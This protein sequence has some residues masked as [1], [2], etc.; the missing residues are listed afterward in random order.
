MGVV[1]KGF[2]SLLAGAALGAVSLPGFL[3]ADPAFSGEAPGKPIPAQSAVQAPEIR[4]YQAPEPAQSALPDFQISYT[5]EQPDFQPTITEPPTKKELEEIDKAK[6]WLINGYDAAIKA[7]DAKKATEQ[8][9]IQKEREKNHSSGDVRSLMETNSA[10]VDNPVDFLHAKDQSSDPNKNGG[11]PLQNSAR[12]DLGFTPYKPLISGIG[13]DTSKPLDGKASRYS[14]NSA[15]GLS[16]ADLKTLGTVNPDVLRP[17]PFDGSVTASDSSQTT[18]PSSASPSATPTRIT[19]F[20]VP[21]AP[22]GR[23]S[24]YYGMNSPVALAAPAIPVPPTANPLFLQRNTGPATPPPNN[25]VLMP[26][27]HA[28][29]AAQNAAKPGAYNPRVK[30]PNDISPFH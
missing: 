10:T 30:D 25:T 22:V 27:N 28:Q 29:T 23:D 14:T 18:D 19:G 6:N 24:P 2:H 9:A 13:S 17:I 7:E 20:L 16:A 4:N 5:P 11:H 3:R 15:H 21:N 8:L 12:T 26:D 1:N